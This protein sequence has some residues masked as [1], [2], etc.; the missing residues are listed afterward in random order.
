MPMEEQKEYDYIQQWKNILDTDVLRSNI[1][2]IA[3]Y[4]MVYELLED[5]IISKPKDFYT[6]IDFDEEV[7]RKYKKY[8]LSL[9]NK[10]AFPIDTPLFY[11]H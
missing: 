3:M 11:R 2:L 10:N 6:L 9:Y 7:Q 8:V 1:N 5:I 4:I